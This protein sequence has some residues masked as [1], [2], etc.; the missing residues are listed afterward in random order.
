MRNF[1]FILLTIFCSASLGANLPDLG[2]PDL[3][4]YDAQTETNLGKA[5]ST[6]LH[7]YYDLVDDP[8][9][10]SYI[11]RL[12]YKITSETGRHRHFKFYVINNNE[13]N[14]FAG[15]NGIIGIH[16]GL[17]NTAKSEDELA[18]VI[19]H[20]IAHVTQRHLSRT[21]EYQSS[22]NVTAIASLIAAILIG[23]QDPSAGIATYMGGMGLNIQQQLKNSRIHEKEADHFGIAYLYDAGYNPYAMGEFFDRLQQA[24]RFSEGSYPEILSTHPV[25]QNRLAEANS[26]A[27]QFPTQ[28]TPLKTKELTL[29]QLRLQARL[30]LNPL[31]LRPLSQDQTCYSKNINIIMSGKNQPEYDLQCLNEAISNSKIEKRHYQLLKADIKTQLNQTSALQDYRL[32][33]E[34]YPSDASIVIHH[35]RA[36][37]SFGR[38]TESVELLEEKQMAYLQTE[39]LYSELARAYSLLNQPAHQYYYSAYLQYEIG[40]DQK[41]IYLLD[42]AKRKIKNKPNK[43]YEKIMALERKINHS[44]PIQT[45]PNNP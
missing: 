41:A 18:S 24:S 14:A 42:Q 13:I 45:K 2:A 8:V 5:F 27:Q 3:K 28:N 17:I 26:R 9:I 16:T 36:L 20:E 29:I 1:I 7:E 39:N 4:E 6:A 22:L 10:N 21:Y 31:T 34:L 19:A 32:L 37:Q 33:Q 38:P 30:K 25:T 12:G 40:N 15:P 11:Q 23:S 44:K 35:A 43:L